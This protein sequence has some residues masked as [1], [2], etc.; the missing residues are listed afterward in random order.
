MTVRVLLDFYHPWPNNAPLFVA[1]K[2]GFFAERDLD[3]ELACADPFR[4]DAL[5]H[6]ERGEVQ[7]GLSYPNRLMARVAAGAPLQSVAAVCARPMES[8]VSPAD[9]PLLHPHELEGK[10]VGYRKSERM[11]ALL[12]HLVELDGGDPASVEHVVMYPSEPM[13]DDLRAGRI[14]AMFGALW[15][16]EGLH[17]PVLA[18]DRLVH[19][20]IDQ[21]GAPAYNAQVL[22]TR[23]D[24]DSGL[25]EALVG[26]TAQGATAAAA[27][28]DAATDIMFEA[29]PYFPRELHR[30]S[31]E[32]VAG[33]W[34]LPNDWGRHNY[35]ELRRYAEWL[36]QAGLVGKEV[37][38]GSVFVDPFGPEVG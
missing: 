30:A 34:G 26:A 14:D 5:A 19:V 16:W 11:T 20:E 37:D 38:L 32:W 10:R 13:P 31:L 33:N 21:I 17:G 6:L 35:P 25:V 7:F 18:G 15:A 12:N 8:L 24:V 22:A 3:V 36:V 9:R 2:L 1:R 27:D 28:A 4:G 29:A 23:T